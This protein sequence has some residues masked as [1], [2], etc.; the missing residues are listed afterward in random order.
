MKLHS[1]L[2]TAFR[3]LPAK[4][5]RNELKI[6]TLS[7]GLT[8]G[9]VLA[10]KV[11]FEQT[12]DDYHSDADRIV[13]LSEAA[14]QNGTLDIYPQTS[15]GTAPMMKEHYP[16]VEEATRITFFESSA[17]LIDSET[18]ERYNAWSVKMADSCYF[19]IFDRECL[20]GDI[21]S[22]LGISGNVAISSKMALAMAHSRNKHSAAAEVIGKKFTIGSRGSDVVLNI[23]GVY[24][25]F[26]ANS[27]SRPDVVIALP[28]IGK[29]MYDGT[30]DLLGNDRYQSYLK[31]RETSS[32]EDLN[33]KM[34]SFVQA[35][36]PVEE[37]KAANVYLSY[38]AKPL[39]GYHLES[40]DVRNTLLVLGIVAFS[41]LL[42]SVLNYMLIVI[43]TCVTR[44]REMALRKCL[45]SDRGETVR[46]MLS[47]ALVHTSLA[48][49]LAAAF[50]LAGKGF[51]ENFLGIGLADLFTGKPLAL[52]IGII[53]TIVLL[54]GFVPAR[55][56]NSIP[57]ATAF[58]N[59]RENRRSWKLWLL[60]VE[61]TLV[62]FLCVLI[63]VISVQ[64]SRMTNADLGFSYENSIE[65]ATPEADMGQHKVLMNEL[66]AMPEVEDACFAY[67]TIF[68]GFSG[69]N[70]RIPGHEEDL[71]NAQDLYYVDDHWLNV[72]EIRLVEGRNFNPDL[73]SDSEVL[74]DTKFA[75]KLKATTGWDDVIGRHVSISEHG[76]NDITIV[77]VF[78]PINLGRFN[79]E[80]D[81]LFS[82][83]KMVFYCNPDEPMGRYH[84]PFQFVRY[85]K[86]TQEA[87]KHTCEVV[88]SALPGQAIYTNPFKTAMV[89]SLKDTLETRNSILA[90][91]IITLLTAILGLVGYTIDEI[92]R[93]SKE[94]AVR[95][96]N[97]ALFGQIRLLFQKDTLRIA[98]PSAVAGC[99]A[100]TAAALK[101]EQNFTMQV[102]VPWWVITGAV[103]FTVIVV[104]LVSDL[105]VNKIANTNPAESIKTE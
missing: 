101:W 57:V 1:Y 22:S 27:S 71:F 21:T 64:Y 9:L 36:L 20:A 92:K 90:G 58:R 82:R 45:G 77:G 24:E 98:I 94:I 55:V 74:V 33:G 104:A 63:G 18:G 39:T 44:S 85:H 59:Y 42:V 15:G 19:K 34:D 5:R 40:T 6:L 3:T 88:Q 35:Y 11:C 38:Q 32:A 4:G 50:L 10:S 28:S 68:P 13:Y 100:G 31:L 84:Y 8:V 73:L 49:V 99:M 105:F 81:E 62:A 72:M 93:R 29:F 56:F 102:G 16:E 95:R 30:S 17:S 54:N 70:V 23:A 80:A 53:L 7:I 14:E 79:S 47:E 97:G 61:F 43:S 41:L 103:L 60:I 52:A 91:S 66:R 87:Y 96:I 2:S 89:E 48:T 25:E 51:V 26:P 78:N 65:I 12:Y 46:M 67:L 76:D 86:F 37:M 83:P 75:E 69:N